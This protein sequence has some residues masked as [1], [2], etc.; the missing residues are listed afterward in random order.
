MARQTY[1]VKYIIVYDNG[2]RSETSTV[3][4]LE[5]PSES[6]AI[7]TLKRQN[8]VPQNAQI[9]VKSFEKR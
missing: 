3:L 8:N 2:Q 9:I 4:N 1:Q 6:L 7:D 5:S